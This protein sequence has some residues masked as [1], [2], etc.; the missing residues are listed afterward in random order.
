MV[1]S[2]HCR[3][4]LPLVLGLSLSGA[5]VAWVATRVDLNGLGQAFGRLDWRW[6][7]VLVLT[8]LSSFLIR[9]VRWQLMLRPIKSLGWTTATANVIVGFMANNLLPARLGEVV[10]A[11]ILGR[12]EG[13]SKV[14]VL[15]SVLVE[16][17]F[18]GLALLVI[19]TSTAY[20]GSFAPE[21]ELLISRVGTLAAVLFLGAM[22]GVLLARIRPNWLLGL[23]KIFV[24]W[25]PQEVKD[26]IFGLCDRGLHAVAF[27]RLD[28]TLPVF[29][30]LSMAVWLVEGVVFLLALPAMSLTANPVLAY[31]TLGLVSFGILLPSAPGYVGVF[32]GCC[33]IAFAAFAIP[34]EIALS[35][36]L[37]V[38]AS[39]F[40]P[41]TLIGLIYLGF[42]GLS[43]KAIWR[44]SQRQKES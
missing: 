10:R 30:L 23:L 8:Y 7:P 43:L 1:M 35:Y 44:E 38:H 17:I 29:L 39:Q 41:T 9:G 14:S 3:L 16:R 31:F 25:A 42:K 34:E 24:F 15:S 2:S 32:Q 13:V 20:L 33:L 21:H 36:G 37:I 28:W 11:Y 19:F 22:A 6:L 26:K 18:D 27:L 5:A 40:I 4:P 12:W